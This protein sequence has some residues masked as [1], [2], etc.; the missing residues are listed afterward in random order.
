MLSAY[1]IVYIFFFENISIKEKKKKWGEKMILDDYHLIDYLI[2]NKKKA[3]IQVLCIKI[4][5]P[6]RFSIA[7]EKY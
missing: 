6:G 2:R 7:E 1:F 5:G 4:R 3:K